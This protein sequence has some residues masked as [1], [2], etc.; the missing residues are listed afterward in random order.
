MDGLLHATG[1]TD[2]TAGPLS[3]GGQ[4]PSGTGRADGGDLGTSRG[5]MPDGGFA[6]D[7]AV[8]PGGYRW[9][10]VDALSDDGQHGLTLIGFIGSV[11][12]P[13]YAWARG[14]S[15]L[16]EAENHVALNVALYGPR[17]AGVAR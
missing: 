5:A 15:G 17:G 1:S 2:A 12:S 6:F 11:F 9:W 13:Y 16:A 8:A 7:A 14:A 3:G 10:Y 4:R